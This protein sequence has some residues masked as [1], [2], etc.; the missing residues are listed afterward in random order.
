VPHW[1]SGLRRGHQDVRRFPAHALPCSGANVDVPHLGGP[2]RPA[3]VSRQ[4]GLK[5]VEQRP[6]RA[7]V[8]HDLPSHDCSSIAVS[9]GNTAASV[10]PPAVGASRNASEPS[11]SG[12]D[13][14][15]LQWAQPR[16]AERV[17]DV[18]H[19]RGQQLTA[20]PT[21]R[22]PHRRRRCVPPPRTRSA[23]QSPGSA[24]SSG[25]RRPD[26]GPADLENNRAVARAASTDWL[27]SDW[28][29][30]RPSFGGS[31][32]QSKPV[33]G[34]SPSLKR[35]TRRRL[36]ERWRGPSWRN[37]EDPGLLT[38]AEVY[39]MVDSLGDVDAAPSGE[40]WTSWPSCTA[41]CG[42]FFATTMKRGC[43]RDSLS[44]GE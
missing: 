20:G 42:W 40:A 35:S 24:P 18:V 9:S 39:A 31:R 14:L 8:Q 43:L 34:R 28:P 19:Q 22:R 2:P 26:G 44:S 17:D 41:T 16:P 30:R 36:S 21:R 27:V 12:V 32:R 4:P 25:Q 3:R 38:E 23:S 37:A 11:S 7:D 10:W 5:V 1:R 33:S 13:R 29:V 15:G 6:Q